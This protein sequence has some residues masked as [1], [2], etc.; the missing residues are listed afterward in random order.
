MEEGQENAD[1]KPKPEFA[2]PHEVLHDKVSLTIASPKGGE[3]PLDQNSVK[4]FESDPVSQTFLKEQKALWTNT[5]K[6]ADMLPRVGE[7]DAIF[8]VG[9]HGRMFLLFFLPF[10]FGII[11]L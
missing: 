2:H 1:T 3:A 4:M 7:F 8:Y 5:H 11:L 6:L 10:S 9:G